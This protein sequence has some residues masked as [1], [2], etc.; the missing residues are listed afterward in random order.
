MKRIYS[1][2]LV[3]FMI[4]ILTILFF[5]VQ[6]INTEKVEIV[7]SEYALQIKQKD[8][9]WIYEIYTN[10]NLFIRQEYIPAVKGKQ[11]FKTEEDAKKIGKLVVSK[12]SQNLFPVISQKDLNSHNIYFEKI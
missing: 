6:N 12:L 7:K 2:F 5:Y 8:S 9:F 4:S 11:V 3:F 1:Y 10:D